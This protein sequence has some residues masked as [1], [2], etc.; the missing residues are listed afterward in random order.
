MGNDSAVC[1]SGD[2]VRNGSK[3]RRRHSQVMGCWVPSVSLYVLFP[4][5]KRNIVSCNF[6]IVS[7][8]S[9]IV[10]CR[11]QGKIK[12]GIKVTHEPTIQI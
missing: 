9:A 5:S 12:K 2:E 11:K 3:L 4:Y 6:F 8:I 7:N 1:A 10:Y